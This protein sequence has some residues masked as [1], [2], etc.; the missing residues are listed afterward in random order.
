MLAWGAAALVR[1][2]VFEVELG[3]AVVSHGDEAETI[4]TVGVA[5]DAYSVSCAR[6][7]VA[8]RISVYDFAF[9]VGFQYMLSNVLAK[10]SPANVP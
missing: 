3:L 2:M 5:G 10:R 4:G 6:L 7:R 8:V 1:A 9:L